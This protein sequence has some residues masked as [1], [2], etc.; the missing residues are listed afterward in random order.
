MVPALEAEGLSVWWDHTIPPGET[1]NSY[2]AQGIAEAKACIVVWSEHSIVSDWVME[3]A[4]IANEGR[5][6][7][8]VQLGGAIP[9]MGFR[10]LQAAPLTNWRGDTNDP[11]WRLLIAS[12]QKLTS[13]EHSPPRVQTPT[14]PAR[15]KR[16]P[17]LAVAVIAIIGVGIVYLL[18][19]TGQHRVA[20][21][22]T[23]TT[24]TVPEQA[25]QTTTTPPVS[26]TAVTTTTPSQTAPTTVRPE[27]APSQPQQLTITCS[28][29]NGPTNSRGE[30]LL[31]NQ[32]TYT[33]L[34]ATTV[35]DQRGYTIPATITSDRIAIDWGHGSTET[36]DRRA[37]TIYVTLDR[38]GD[39]VNTTARGTCRRVE[40]NAF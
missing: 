18:F 3:E 9:P 37:G 16:G 21:I 29:S 36:I 4:S 2:I 38:D 32:V 33:L 35:R 11:T 1:W 14:R 28:W 22:S 8:P 15:P 23:T 40:R 34:S 31:A 20:E 24:S 6:L 39:G 7:V 19:G 26:T 17:G 25:T 10:R 12:I 27:Q 5:R 13:G 30:Y